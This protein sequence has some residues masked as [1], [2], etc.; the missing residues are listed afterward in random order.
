M[1]FP[2]MKNVMLL[3]ALIFALTIHIADAEEQVIKQAMQGFPPTRESQ[4]TMQNYRLFAM[5]VRL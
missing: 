1:M 3:I 4:A 2:V 5:R